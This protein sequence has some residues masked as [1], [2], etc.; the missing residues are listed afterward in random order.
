MC[1]L[2]CHDAQATITTPVCSVHQCRDPC[3]VGCVCINPSQAFW[4]TAV[5]WDLGLMLSSL[6]S[7]LLWLLGQDS[8]LVAL[9]HLGLC[10]A[11]AQQWLLFHIFQTVFQL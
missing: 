6:G 2:W 3:A 9:T 7:E 5:S 1:V 11:L 10:S 8:L 4:S